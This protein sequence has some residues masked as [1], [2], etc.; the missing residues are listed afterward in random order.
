MNVEEIPLVF[1][2]GNDTLTGMVHRPESPSHRGVLSLVAGGPQYRAGYCRQ[3]VYMAREF[4]SHGIPVMRFDHRG[5]GDSDGKFL[6]FLHVEKD[7]AAAIKAFKRT[8]PELREVVLW[9]GC[10]AASGIMI[11]AHRHPE[12][13][14]MI[15]SNP[16]AHSEATQ[17]VVVRK[18]YMRRLKDPSFWIKVF[19][20]GFNPLPYAQSA[21]RSVLRR[22]LPSDPVAAQTGNG[23]GNKHDLPFTELML[24]G[25]KQFRGQILLIMSGQ[26]LTSEE[27]D[28]LVSNTPE[29]QKAYNAASVTRA[30]IAL[31]DQA[32][33]TI[34][35]RDELLK[36]ARAWLLDKS[37]R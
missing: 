15:I 13:T 2:C 32:F 29:W 16:Y 21:I 36:T 1:D 9:G 20:L 28:V 27:F 12:V 26:S 35:A 33:S 17:A 34:E 5:I 19:K 14:G 10:N 8:V 4:S 37:A 7:I 25:F 11:T 31:A 23:N 6:D 30:D 22:I 3:L 18:H 24:S